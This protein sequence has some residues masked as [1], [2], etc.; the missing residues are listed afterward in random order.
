VQEEKNFF[1]DTPIPHNLY[2]A[3]R[4]LFDAEIKKFIFKK[5]DKKQELIKIIQGSDIS[6]DDKKEWE[7]LVNSSPDDFVGNLLEMYSKFPAEIGWFNDIY[8][9]KKTAFA[10]ME[11]EKEKAD[12]M[13]AEIFEEEKR[14]LEELGGAG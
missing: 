9:R 12:A 6:E 3:Y 4:F 1:V 10:L 5:V 11:N 14:K 7:F 2:L 8:K 13:L